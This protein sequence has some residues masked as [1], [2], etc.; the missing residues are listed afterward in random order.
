MRVM[1]TRAVIAGLLRHPSRIAVHSEALARIADTDPRIDVLLDIADA[2]PP[3]ES[4]KLTTILAG[5]GLTAPAPDDFARIRYP[6]VVDG[7][8]PAV[9][10]EAL[11]AAIVILAE[12][13]ALDAAIEAATARLDFDEQQRLLKRKLEFN[14]RLRQMAGARAVSPSGEAPNTMAE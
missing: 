11:E 13:P 9:A 8:D 2:D 4:E 6:F 7:T 3:L 10:A 12:E 5:N 1:L 14:T